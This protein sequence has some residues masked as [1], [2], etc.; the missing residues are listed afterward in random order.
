MPSSRPL[1]TLAA[2]L[3]FA[4]ALSL[5]C[6]ESDEDQVSGDIAA[7]V[8]ESKG[9]CR[10]GNGFTQLCFDDDGNCYWRVGND[11]I[12]FG[13]E[14]YI[15]LCVPEPTEYSLPVEGELLNCGVC[16]GA[17]AEACTGEAFDLCDDLF[18]GSA[19][20]TCEEC[21]AGME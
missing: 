19:L 21:R 20:P 2:S 14:G 16:G 1:G 3:A 12:C 15:N 6:G 9:L 11:G 13:D 4:A 18:M 5:G 10:T 7:L 17:N 8:C